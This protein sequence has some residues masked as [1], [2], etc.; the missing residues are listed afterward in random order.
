MGRDGRGVK[1]ASESSIEISFMYRGTRCRERIALK[2]T[3]AN[4][5]RAEN[6]RA[7]ILHAIAIN[8]FDYTATFPQSSN[9]AKFADQVGDVQTIEAFLDKWLDRQKKHL[10]ASTYNGYRKIVVGQ[11]IPW[12]GTI[13][14]SALRKKD[15]RAKLEPMNATNKTMANIQSVLRKA[16][17][18]A[19]EDEL[20]EVNPLAR[21]CYSKVEA[22]QSKDD[23]DPFTKEEQAA[24]FAQATGQGRNLLQFAFWTGLR[25]SELVA[26]DW[27][28]VDLV[29]GVVMVTRALTQHS[30]A[31]ESTKTNAGRREVKLLERAMHALQEQKAFTWSKGEEVFQ[32]PRLERRWEGDQ[33]IRKTLWTGILQNA[34]VRYRNPYQTRHTYASMMLSAGE[35]PMWVAKQM[36]HADWTMIARVYGRWM[37]DADQSAGS[38]AEEVFGS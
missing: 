27:A 4:L 14:L 23:I 6:H 8:S 7:A 9:A 20:I 10:K 11:L 13:M 31:A 29:R 38:K 1:A 24:I 26:L 15:V 2:P 37:P 19:I 28:D 36:G 33:P 32:N 16:L 35:H 30:K 22:P 3:S 34:G 5:K 12:F 17:D 18:D 25:T 21:W